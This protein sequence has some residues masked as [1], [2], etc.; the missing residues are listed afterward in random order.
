MKT[1]DKVEGL[2]NKYRKKVFYCIYK[3]SP[4]KTQNS[5]S[6][7]W[8]KEKFLPV[9]S[10]VDE[11]LHALSVL[12]LRKRYFPKYRFFSLKMSAWATKSWQHVCKDF[13]SFRWWGQSERAHYL[14][15]VHKKPFTVF[16][17]RQNAQFILTSQGLLYCPASSF[18]LIVERSIGCLTIS[19]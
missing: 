2:Q 19:K 12:V 7:H 11:V 10:L 14:Y 9:W 3:L 13:P 4:E 17:K 8:I 18:L 15:S 5:F 16:T 1:R 6:W